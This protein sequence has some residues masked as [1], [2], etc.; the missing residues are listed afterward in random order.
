MGLRVLLLFLLLW[1]MA[2]SANAQASK[3]AETQ[4]GVLSPAEVQALFPPT[5][6]FSG[7]TTTVQLRNSAGVRWSPRKQ[8]MF[9]V[10]DAGGYSSGVS[11][12]YQFYVVT[13]V[14]VEI[15]GKHLAPGAYGAGF[16]NGQFEVMDM[17]GTELFHA[18]AQRDAT[19]LRP[20]PLQVTAAA[21][22]RY[23]LYVGRDFVEFSQG[24]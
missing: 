1:P 9:G 8:T 5:V 11:Q 13:D 23:R 12:R 18:A 16:L 7:E 6:Y 21:G 22:G 14:P 19:M 20:R 10:I 17:S 4:T 3:P 15:G 24:H 2:G